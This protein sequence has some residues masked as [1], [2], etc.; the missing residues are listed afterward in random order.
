MICLPR[1]PPA[2][3]TEHPESSFTTTDVP[4][5]E[6][7]VLKTS[8]KKGAFGEVC[9]G[10]DTLTGEQVA[11]KIMSKDE[12]NVNG[13]DSLARE[14][15]F[16]KMF[17]HPNVVKTLDVIEYSDCVMVVQEWCAKGDLFD[18][19]VPLEGISDRTKLAGYVREFF[20]SV[21]YLHSLGVVHC[22]IKPENVVVKDDDSIRLIDFGLSGYDWEVVDP[23]TGTVPYM[24]PEMYCPSDGRA[25]DAKKSDAWSVGIVLY[26]LL[27]GVLPWSMASRHDPDYGI[28]QSRGNKFATTS[29]GWSDS[30]TELM[31]GLLDPNPATR[32]TMR[33]AVHVV[34][35]G[36]VCFEKVDATTKPTPGGRLL[37]PPTDSGDKWF[38]VV[39]GG[40][41]LSD[42][43][44]R[45]TPPEYRPDV[46]V[47]FVDTESGEER[48]T[49]VEWDAL[50]EW[51]PKANT[52]SRM[53]E[54]DSES[55]SDEETFVEDFTQDRRTFDWAATPEVTFT[56]YLSN[57]GI[58]GGNRR[59][60][61]SMSILSLPSCHNP[62]YEESMDLTDEAENKCIFY[63]DSGSE[64]ESESESE[65]VV[66]S[67]S[68]NTDDVSP[69]SVSCDECG[70]DHEF[71]NRNWEDLLC[72][73]MSYSTVPV[74]EDIAEV[75]GEDEEISTHNTSNWIDLCNRHMS[76]SSLP[77][78][79]SFSRSTSKNSLH[80]ADS[81]DGKGVSMPAS[82]V[83]SEEPS[84]LQSVLSSSSL[85]RL[86][87]AV[88]FAT[89]AASPSSTRP[90]QSPH[91]IKFDST[92]LVNRFRHGIVS[93]V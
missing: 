22:D 74:F 79:E 32:W 43:G 8:Y 29:L 3:D 80:V 61:R 45:Y 92:H 51:S 85:I 60:D 44:S 42:S 46:E 16:C 66:E 63:V 33:Q 4:T 93:T 67:D 26:A 72:R 34:R 56:H 55:E 83:P 38:G 53:E 17:D 13:N 30:L 65:Q 25:I 20:E 49:D 52:V 54:N 7:Y 40:A 6:R 89:T 1:M 70:D 77:V 75:E 36:T 37:L 14:V 10:I 18:M 88:A 48:L 31:N 9:T 58:R 2:V 24:S 59:T 90:G 47:A 5:Q 71:S 91:E 82:P 78:F 35:Q 11:I 81:I 23:L 87:S 39:D 21:D 69:E 73:Q 28:W 76:F 50:P 19:T 68:D 12:E 64:S 62:K 15:T 41:G 84:I 57:D 86:R 27:T